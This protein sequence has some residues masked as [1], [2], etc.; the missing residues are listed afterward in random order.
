MMTLTD[1]NL[2]VFG[3]LNYLAEISVFLSESRKVL[4]ELF[5]SFHSLMR[6][7]WYPTEPRK[8]DFVA[9][10]TAWRRIKFV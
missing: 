7:D 3:A 4:K 9:I 1:S 2:I 5:S 10:N 6:W 8:A